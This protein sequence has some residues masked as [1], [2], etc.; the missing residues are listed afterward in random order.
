MKED[1][2]R[3]LVACMDSKQWLRLRYKS[4]GRGFDSPIGSLRL[5]IDLMFSAAIWPWSRLSL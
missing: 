5:F 4:E 2:L 1:I 3:H